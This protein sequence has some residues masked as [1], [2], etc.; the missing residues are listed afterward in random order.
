MFEAEGIHPLEGGILR[1]KYRRDRRHGMPIE[2]PL[3]VLS[4]ATR[5]TRYASCSGI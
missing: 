2:N 4:R 1:L 5:R 3:G